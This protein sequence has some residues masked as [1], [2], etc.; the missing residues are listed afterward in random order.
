[1]CRDVLCVIHVRVSWLRLCI[2]VGMCLHLMKYTF[3][4]FIFWYLLM[5]YRFFFLFNFCHKRS[6]KPPMDSDRSSLWR[7]DE[8]FSPLRF[9]QPVAHAD[10]RHRVPNLLL[11]EMMCQDFDSSE[12]TSAQSWVLQGSEKKSV[13]GVP[14]HLGHPADCLP[15]WSFLEEMGCLTACKSDWVL[16]LSF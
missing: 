11:T 1:M 5:F 8:S 3:T 4:F 7:H 10:M 12:P 9:P 6:D 2:Y 15:S 13:K 16:F 14:K